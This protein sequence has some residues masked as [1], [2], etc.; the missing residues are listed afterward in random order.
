MCLKS[1][2]TEAQRFRIVNK[3]AL[4]KSSSALTLIYL[5]YFSWC[6]SYEGGVGLILPYF[7][8]SFFRRRSSGS[9]LFISSIYPSVD[10]VCA[11]AC[12]CMC[13]CF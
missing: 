6:A 11:R 2:S 1:N 13:V 8:R 9:K 10:R 3:S 4:P 12:V 7:S 5:R